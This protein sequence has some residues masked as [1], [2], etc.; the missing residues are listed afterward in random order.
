MTLDRPGSASR[1]MIW[2]GWLLSALP[3][4]LLLFSGSMKLLK[5]ED[6]VKGFEHLG[7]T[8]KTTNVARLALRETGHATSIAIDGQ[9]I[10]V[11]PGAAITLREKLRRFVE[12][13]RF[14]KHDLSP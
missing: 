4:L 14:P 5:P 11:K 12:R 2:V 3:S 8:V 6:V 7:Y 1:A 9:T 13:P 10:Q